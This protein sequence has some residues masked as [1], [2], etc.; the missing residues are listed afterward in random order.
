MRSVAEAIRAALLTGVPRD[1]VMATRALV[2]AWRRGE[3]AW[4]FSAPM[5]D[6]PRWPAERP[7][8]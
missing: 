1:K 3:F 2:R 7:G 5:P 8:W 4:D 6:R